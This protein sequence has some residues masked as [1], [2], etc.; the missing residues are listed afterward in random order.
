MTSSRACLTGPPQDGRARRRARLSGVPPFHRQ[1][2][3]ETRKKYTNGAHTPE[4]QGRGSV[5][6]RLARPLSGRLSISSCFL[7][8]P[9]IHLSIYLS[10][11]PSISIYLS[12][13]LHLYLYFFSVSLGLS[14]PI[15]L[16]ICLSIYLYLEI[17]I[18]MSIYI[19]SF[20]GLPRQQQPWR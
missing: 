12:I 16:S 5:T 17:Q 9:Y 13:Y 4:L 3:Q 15:H 20:S 14:I 10:I 1:Q 7:L 6:R 8:F 19:N 18:H 2:R 11:Y